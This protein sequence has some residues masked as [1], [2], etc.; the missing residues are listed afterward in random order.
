MEYMVCT[1][2]T[3]SLPG[4]VH[5]SGDSA[6]LATMMWPQKKKHKHDHFN[7]QH[8]QQ[9]K[10]TKQNKTCTYFVGILYGFDQIVHL[11]NPFIV[12]LH[13]VIHDHLLN[14]VATSDRHHMKNSINPP[15]L[16]RTQSNTGCAYFCA[17]LHLMM[18]KSHW[19]IYH[20]N[21]L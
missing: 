2:L 16:S 18:D 17:L 11:D 15:L 1:L 10:N 12:A 13:I 20:I 14:F 3:I 4:I 7:Q 21:I 19:C 6:T 5:R 9:K 8:E